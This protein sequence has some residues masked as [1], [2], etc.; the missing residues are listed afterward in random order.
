[1]NCQMTKSIYFGSTELNQLKA[2]AHIFFPRS[3]RNESF[4]FY[5]EANED[6][7][8]NKLFHF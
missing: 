3:E 1:M 2:L 5:A 6:N 7:E 8:T 4:E